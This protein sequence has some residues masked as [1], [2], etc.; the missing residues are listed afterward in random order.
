M[1]KMQ[2]PS[3]LPGTVRVPS[4]EHID[5]H[6]LPGARSKLSF[7]R[8]RK[9]ATRD[10]DDDAGRPVQILPTKNAC[11]SLAEEDEEG[12]PA[13]LIDETARRDMR[14]ARGGLSGGVFGAIQRQSHL[15]S[16][17]SEEEDL[18]MPRFTSAVRAASK[19]RTACSR[20]FPKTIREA[21]HTGR[22]APATEVGVDSE[23][24]WEE[25]GADAGDA[26]AP[27]SSFL[28]DLALGESSWTSN[29]SSDGRQQIYLNDLNDTSAQ[30]SVDFEARLFDLGLLSREEL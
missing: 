3:D 9:A 28:P 24:P 8:M 14:H 13:Q 27:A 12:L 11:A 17:R 21:V 5:E 26:K 18:Q 4:D 20:S 7:R 15:P 10:A 16:V 2:P 1:L 25:V 6:L 29:V 22:K 30:A 19:G 23:M